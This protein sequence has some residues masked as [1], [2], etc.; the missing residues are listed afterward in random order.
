MRVDQAGEGGLVSGRFLWVGQHL[1][2]CCGFPEI[3]SEVSFM[4]AVKQLPLERHGGGNRIGA[5]GPIL[6]LAILL[7]DVNIAMIHGKESPRLFG[8]NSTSCPSRD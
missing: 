2:D 8:L 6:E 7:F 4:I 1:E 5:G 3:V